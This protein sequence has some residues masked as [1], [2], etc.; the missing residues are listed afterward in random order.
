MFMKTSAFMAI[1]IGICFFVAFS[2]FCQDKTTL[3]CEV[4]ETSES[5]KSSSAKLTGIRYILLRHANS[6]DREMFSK[7]L[8]EHSETEVTFI[9]K[10]KEY[11]GILCRLANCFGRGLLVYAGDESPVKRDI[12]TVSLPSAP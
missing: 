5:F 1:L 2:G 11:K 12:I 4:M 10:E 3:P 8:S 7:W 6:A 9:F